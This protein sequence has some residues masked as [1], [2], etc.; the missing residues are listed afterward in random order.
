MMDRYRIGRIEGKWINF[1][2]PIQGGEFSLMADDS[3]SSDDDCSS[4]SD[5]STL[6]SSEATDD[7]H[8]SQAEL[9]AEATRKRVSASKSEAKSE[10][11]D[12]QGMTR[13]EYT[14]RMEQ[15]EI[16]DDHRKFP[17]LDPITQGRIEQKYQELHERIKRE[18]LYDCP[19]IEYGKECLRYSTLFAGFAIAL[20]AGWYMTSASFL[21]IFWHQIMFT[22]H[23][24]GHMAITHNFVIDSLIA[25]FVG[26]FCCGL[27]VGWWKSSHN[28][29]HLIT[30]HPVSIPAELTDKLVL[31][32]TIL[33]PPP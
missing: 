32:L 10:K 23:D 7:L 18:G 4:Q 30:N 11:I 15:K 17:P 24:G 8:E 29:H 12:S 2:P 14:A 33:S 31:K 19:Y 27:S 16:D 25:I 1:T 5:T 22:A 21:G 6:P 9:K 26:D 3:S 20:K 13:E 28:V